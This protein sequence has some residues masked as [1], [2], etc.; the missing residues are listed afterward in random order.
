MTVL[1]LLDTTSPY[2][3][4]VCPRYWGIVDNISHVKFPLLT[5]AICLNEVMFVVVNNRGDHVT[6]NSITKR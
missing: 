5:F 4:L 3:T 6:A 1:N 2:I